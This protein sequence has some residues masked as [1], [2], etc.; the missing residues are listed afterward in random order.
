MAQNDRAYEIWM[1]TAEPCCNIDGRKVRSKS[2]RGE[3]FVSKVCCQSLSVRAKAPP[4]SE[5]EPPTL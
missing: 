3:R 1:I 4:P 5:A 2:N